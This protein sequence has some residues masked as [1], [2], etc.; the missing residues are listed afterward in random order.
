MMRIAV[1]WT[2]LSGYFNACLREL[3]AR[4]DVELLVAH[5]AAGEDAPFDDGQFSWMSARTEYVSRPNRDALLEQV[6]RFAPDVL[7]VS[8]WH[9]G[10][11]RH[12]LQRL[13]PRPLRVLCMDNQWLGTWRQRLGVIASPWYVRRLYDAAFLPGERQACFARRLGFP[14]D[15]IWQGLY[16]P[17]TASFGG[18]A[19][20]P[21]SPLPR[22]FGYLG[23]LS[24]EKGIQDLLWAYEAYRASSDAPWALHVAGAGQVRPELDRHEGVAHRGFVQPAQLSDWMKT[25]GCLVVPSRFEP[26]GVVLSEAATTGLPIIATDA[27]GAVPHLVHDFAN[28]RIAHAG[29]VRSIAG[30]MTHVASRSDEERL[31]MGR[32]SRGLASPYTPAR[33]ADTV[34]ARSA[35]LLADRFVP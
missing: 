9:I 14:D 1:L 12:V 2:R 30:C 13:R 15:R 4:P 11:F 31:A 24:P 5:Q 10:E 32:V 35:E 18:G 29:D 22:A 21:P 19:G 26:W 3:A 27:C 28:G 6:R 16:C 25:I 34:I 17:D 20:E 23:R 33:W 8:S 7:L